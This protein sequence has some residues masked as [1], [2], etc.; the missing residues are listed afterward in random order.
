MN[1]VIT[2]A[3]LAISTIAAA[4]NDSVTICPTCAT[5]STVLTVNPSGNPQWCGP[6]QNP[7]YS[8]YCSPGVS[9]EDAKGN[10]S[11]M[12][13]YPIYNQSLNQNGVEF[14]QFD[15]LGTYAVTAFSVTPLPVGYTHNL[16]YIPNGLPIYTQTFALNGGAGWVDTVVVPGRK[17]QLYILSGS[18]TIN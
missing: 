15:G 16:L 3:I 8:V 13:Y 18:I 14:F 6:A 12:F 10:Q 11:R 17:P 2:A 9:V 4:Q 7:A 5:A 1:K